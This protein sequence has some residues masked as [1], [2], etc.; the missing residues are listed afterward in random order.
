MENGTKWEVEGGLGEYGCKRRPDESVQ[1][2]GESFSTTNISIS[3]S[4]SIRGLRE[5]G[6]KQ[7][8]DKSVEVIYRQV[9]TEFLIDFH[10]CL[11]ILSLTFKGNADLE[12]REQKFRLTL[13]SLNLW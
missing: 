9:C 2:I 3:I 7:M 4:I 13:T 6:C 1:V 10:W 12:R 5:Y 8:L 11:M